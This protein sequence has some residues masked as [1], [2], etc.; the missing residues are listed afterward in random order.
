MTDTVHGPAPAKAGSPGAGAGSRPADALAIETEGLTCR[1]G[2]FVAVD[3]V[4]LRVPAGAVYGLLGPN[5]AGK[6]TLIRALLGLVPAT[7]RA[8]VLGL[9]PAR[10]AA[11]VRARV[12]YMSQRFSLYPDLT[13]E[14][15]LL[16][17]GRVYG[18]RGERFARRVDEL[19]ERTGLTHHRRTRAA[20][21]G[22]G[23]R[24]RLAFACAVLHEPALLLLDEPTSGVDPGVRRS[25][26]DTMYA[27]A[28]TGT[29]VLVTTHH[30]D[31]AEQCDR[32]GMMLRGRLVAEAPPAEI[33]ARYAG[34]GSLAEAFARIAAGLAHPSA[35]PSRD[36]AT[37]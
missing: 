17:Y 13:A 36:E 19:L 12:G 28:D 11:A 1:F 29:T 15:N 8:R 31:E 7:G 23:L 22:A 33:R 5:G 16:F 10:Q 14:E 34:G 20:S 35:R 9:D 6:T 26:W 3:G 24:Q 32:L 18:L 37:G 25:F 4:S 30:M 2:D 27:L 21:L